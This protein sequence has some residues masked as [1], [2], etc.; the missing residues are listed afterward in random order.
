MSSRSSCITKLG[1]GVGAYNSVVG[2]KKLCESLK[3]A[4][5]SV[6]CPPSPEILD[7]LDEKI[8]CAI[9]CCCLDEPNTTSKG[10]NRYQNCVA[11]TL[12]VGQAGDV[13][14][15]AYRMNPEV[16][17]SM[18]TM[19]PTPVGKYT[20]PLSSKFST[21]ADFEAG[22]GLRRPDVVVRQG[23]GG[24]LMGSSIRKIYEMKFEKDGYRDTYGDG[25]LE[26]YEK[27]GGGK[28]KVETLD[29]ER[30]CDGKDKDGKRL[31]ESS[32]DT[33]TQAQRDFF[34]K[35]IQTLGG[36]G[37]GGKLGGLLG[38]KGGKSPIPVPI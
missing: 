29:K 10:H 28:N 38:G 26:A 16:S 24:P 21:K 33:I 34:D 8:L 11:N 15:P 31:L 3:N 4:G 18:K 2:S 1:P 7:E 9:F 30:C 35:I 23:N 6:P 37:L 27:I 25:Q 12:K 17:Y 5:I 14:A 19:P 32:Y 13:N 22:T 20:D 36:K